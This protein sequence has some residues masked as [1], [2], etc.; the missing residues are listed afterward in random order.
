MFKI[1]LNLSST[2]QVSC[3]CCGQDRD[4]RKW[5]HVYE[6]IDKLGGY[7][8]YDDL[9]GDFKEVLTYC[10]YC[11][12]VYLDNIDKEY[13]DNSNLRNLILAD[14][15]QE[16]IKYYE[17]FNLPSWL[18]AWIKYAQISNSLGQYG[19]S[20]YAWKKVYDYG[21]EI[22]SFDVNFGLQQMCN[23]YNKIYEERIEL[24]GEDLVFIL[25]AMVDVMRITSQFDKALIIYNSLQQVIDNSDERAAYLLN[26][27]KLLLDTQD[28]TTPIEFC[29]TFKGGK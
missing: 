10:P 23:V 29:K 14:E 18:I 7:I 22:E 21:K 12:Y 15:Y 17:G 28:S 27:L 16:S 5:K 3:P 24:S 25:S 11:H 4:I 2:N 13:L 19:K 26:R 9:N 8:I 1:N 6:Q 20:M